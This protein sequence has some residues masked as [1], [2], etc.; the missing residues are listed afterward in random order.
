MCDFA[1]FKRLLDHPG[2]S[3]DLTDANKKRLE[4]NLVTIGKPE[5]LEAV[6]IKGL[7]LNWKYVMH[8]LIDTKKSIETV[9]ILLKHGFDINQQYEGGY[10]GYQ[11]YHPIMTA[12]ENGLLG[13]IKLFIDNNVDVNIENQAYANDGNTKLKISPLYMAVCWKYRVY[14]D[15]QKYNSKTHLN[16]IKTLLTAGAKSDYVCPT[17]NKSVLHEA[18]ELNLSIDILKLLMEHGA[19]MD[20]GKNYKIDIPFSKKSYLDDPQTVELVE[21]LK[22]NGV[23][24][25]NM[26]FS[27]NV[28]Y[29]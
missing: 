13:I 14:H 4:Q 20:L 11:A 18:I 19:K 25:N 9:K 16:I 10:D 6:L 5:F 29:D 8:N 15:H 1:L 21:F 27:G 28:Y 17:S 7:P 23:S 26:S 12:V 2:T 22:T 3:I 24:E